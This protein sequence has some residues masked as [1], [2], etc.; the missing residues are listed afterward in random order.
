MEHEIKRLRIGRRFGVLFLANF[1]LSFHLFFT[2]YMNSSFITT[3]IGEKFVGLVYMVSSVVSIATLIYVTRI[4]KKFGN[5]KILLYLTILEFFLFLGMAFVKDKFLIILFFITYSAIFPIML[6]NFDVFLETYTKKE[7]NTGNIRGT[8]LTITNTALIFAPLVAGLMLTNGDYWKIYLSAALFLIPF[9]FLITKFKNFE[10]PQ[11]HNLHI[12]QTLQCIRKDKNLYNIFMAQ[13]VMRIFFSWMV[14]YMPIYLHQY[15]GFSWAEIGVMTSIMLLPFVLVEYPAGK[16]ADKLFGEKELLIIGFLITAAFTGFVSFLTVQNFA[17]WAALLF[18]VRVGASLIE[19]MSE[20]YFFK[21]VSGA[22]NTTISFFRITN[23]LAYIVGPAIASIMLMF[24][25]Y[26]F[27][28]VVL[29]II[30]LYSIKFAFRIKD[31]V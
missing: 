10:D 17:I 12:W 9:L 27:I 26:Q 8:F 21:H 31:T 29:G 5:Y 30:L 28:F 19:V 15:I 22:D 18:T 20:I 11:Y 6:F 4:L 2:L 3:F 25:D 16:I 23:P 24:I 7:S 13:F 1:V 14:I